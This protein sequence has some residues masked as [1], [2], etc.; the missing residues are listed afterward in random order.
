MLGKQIQHYKIIE[1]L[2]AGG[3]GEVYLAEDTT[4]KRRV[5]LKLL[6]PAYSNDPEFVGR[7]R[8]EAQAAAALDHPNIVTVHELGEHEGQLF[9]TMQYVRGQTLQELIKSGKLTLEQSLDIA[10]QICEGLSEAHQAGIVHRDIKPANIIYTKDSVAKILDFG[11]A[12]ISGATKLTKEGS[13]LGT[14]QYQSPEQCR[15]EE[16]DERSD[17]FSLGIVLY[18][19]ITGKLPFTGDYE[20]SVRYAISHE[21]AQPLSR[22]ASGVTDDIQRIVSKLLEKDPALRYQNAESVISDL[23]GLDRDAGPSV[24][25]GFLRRRRIKPIRASVITALTVIGIVSAYFLIERTSVQEQFGLAR[26]DITGWQNSIAVLPLR[27]FSSNKDHEYFSDGMTD[28]II[29]KLSGIKNLKVISMTSVM[30][31]KNPDRDLKKIG[32]DLQV[33]TILEGSIQLE[34]NRLRVRAQLINV[35]DDAHLWTQT[36]NREL[37]SI[38]DVQDDISQAL[39]NAMRIELFGEDTTIITRRYT[40]NIEAYNFYMRG[41]HLWSKRTQRDLTKAIEYFEKAIEL[42]S[43]YA[44]AYSGLADAWAVIRGYID[45]P[46]TVS[47]AEAISKAKEAAEMAIALDGEL[48]EAHASLGLVLNYGSDLEGAEKEFLRAIELN[49]GYGWAR[50]WHSNLLGDMARYPDQ[51]REEEIAFELNPMS[52]PLINNRA[53]RKWLTLEW[54]ESEELYQRLIEME[55]NRWRSYTAYA[56]LLIS[57][58]RNDDAIR[59]Y[60]LAVQIDE[61]AYKNLALAYD[62]IGDFEKALWAASEYMKSTSD[63]HDAYDTRGHIYVLNGMPDSAISSFKKAL[64][65]EPD[66]VS[67]IWKLGHVYMFRQEYANAES[68][69]QVL[70]SST[71]KYIRGRGRIDLTQIPLHQGKFSKA[72][73]MLDELKDK[74]LADSLSGFYQIFGIMKRG[75]IYHHLYIDD[76]ELAISEY[77]KVIKIQ[78]D[79]E[80][81]D[82]SV[83]PAR[84]GIAVSYA[85]S[86]DMRKADQ[87]MG[88]LEE[89]IEKYGPSALPYYWVGAGWLEMEKENFDAAATYFENGFKVFP[90]YFAQREIAR[91]YL[92]AGRVNDAVVALEKTIHGYLDNR[93]YWPTWYVM[94]HYYLGQA[95]EAAGRNDEAIEQYETLLDIWRDA[96][97]GIKIIEDAKERLAKLKS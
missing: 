13:T 1:K 53:K 44:M 17:L 75:F 16:I 73:A 82:W 88:E 30:R 91:S 61:H 9:I 92:G 15:G 36:Y 32:H 65:L 22:F 34:G 43:N 47:K 2:G 21:E 4:L 50:F 67:S 25:I 68:L 42:D 24:K 29:G 74:A 41:R 33:N 60:S 51:I 40:Q 12:K 86:G 95:Y 3:M 28:A 45:V 81:N 79:I 8:H 6:A 72:L 57:M 20:E 59:Q 97:D 19:T 38:F 84:G 26:K 70:A 58:G 89:D 96:D 94:T 56:G 90:G 49:P 39:V 18:E 10:Q 7:F 46:G 55:P 77:E 37:E 87:L 83:A 14:V 54:E 66:F 5:A 93:G 23:K 85:K 35:A 52:I 63:K 76:Q 11:L 62:R 48:A 69:F 27:D 31:Y 71:N 64:K 80:P 78:E